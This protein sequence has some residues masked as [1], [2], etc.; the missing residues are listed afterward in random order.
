MNEMNKPKSVNNT[1]FA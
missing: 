1:Q